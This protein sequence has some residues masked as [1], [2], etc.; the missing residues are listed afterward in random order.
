MWIILLTALFTSYSRQL[1]QVEH[2]GWQEAWIAKYELG[3]IQ[4]KDH[5]LREEIQR[6]KRRT[7]K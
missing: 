3:Q 7:T 2:E 1:R 6:L 5:L 4:K